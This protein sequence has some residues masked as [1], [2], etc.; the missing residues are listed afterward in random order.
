[1]E[2][3]PSIGLY[4]VTGSTV[5]FDDDNNHTVPVLYVASGPNYNNLTISGDDDYVLEGP[6][7]IGGDLSILDG[8]FWQNTGTTIFPLTVNGNLIINGGDYYFSDGT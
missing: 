2:M 7:T 5:D 4:T 6:M 8:Q 1:D 3:T